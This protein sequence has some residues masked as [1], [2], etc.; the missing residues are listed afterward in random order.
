MKSPQSAIVVDRSRGKSWLSLEKRSILDPFGVRTVVVSDR[1]GPQYS[2]LHEGTCV[3]LVDSLNYESILRIATDHGDLVGMSTCSELFLEDV[4]AVR[5]ALG[6]P[7]PR[8]DDVASMRDKWIMKQIAFQA[9]I[10][11][12]WGVLA[13]DAMTVLAEQT[14]PE[15]LFLKP[16]RLSGSRGVR[17]MRDMN[18]VARTL[19]EIGA[20]LEDFLIE[21]FI[22]GDLYHIDGVVALGRIEFVLSRYS[23]PTHRSGGPTPLS[24]HTVDDRVLNAHASAFI[25]R[26]V[27]AWG[28]END[29]FHCEAFLLDNMFIFCEIAGRPGGAGVS[30]VFDLITARDLRWVKTALDL[31]LPIDRL[32]SR[33][34]RQY[35]AGGWTVA[36]QPL[37]DWPAAIDSKGL[38]LHLASDIRMTSG[39]RSH[40]H[41]GVGAATFV[42]GSDSTLE[43]QGLIDHYEGQIQT[44]PMIETDPS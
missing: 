10:P 14:C 30:E 31:G 40:G 22:D 26:V 32:P 18:D 11:T 21:E 15:R 23:R 24:S 36:Y 2:D 16:R 42:F 38:T 25:Q 43:V 13:S 8:P 7:G 35:E 4:A 27:R 19:R 6:L 41:A 28:I 37:R 12:A 9:G 34:H 1:D 20:S 3:H 5:E 39:Q 44:I 29:V 33:F 17:E